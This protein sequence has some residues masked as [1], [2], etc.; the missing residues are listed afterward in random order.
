MADQDDLL[1]GGESRPKGKK[2][3]C[4]FCDCV[5]LPDGEHTG[6]SAK[7]KKLRDAED[8]NEKLSAKVATLEAE[9]VTLKA[10]V[11]EGSRET[12]KASYF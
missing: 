3:T 11:S 8:A 7:A 4:S 5:L 10:K 6:L 12:V 2:I 1:G 9:I